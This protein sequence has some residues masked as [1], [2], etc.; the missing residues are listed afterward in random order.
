MDLSPILKRNGKPW[1]KVSPLDPQPEP[2][3]LA[4]L[5]AEVGRR[6]SQ[7][8]LLDILKEADLRIGFTPLFKSSTPH[9]ILSREILQKRLL[10]CEPIQ[11]LPVVL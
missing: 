8:Y 9:E 3:N 4:S 1:I 11:K 6:W 5:K 2:K 10:L 7:V